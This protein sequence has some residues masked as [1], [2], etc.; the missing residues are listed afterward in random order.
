MCAAAERGGK[1]GRVLYQLLPESK[2]I[3]LGRLFVE[4]GDGGMREGLEKNVFA[5]HR[6]RRWCVGGGKKLS[7]LFTLSGN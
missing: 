7:L 2:M 4:G 3:H 6:P 1:I 5:C